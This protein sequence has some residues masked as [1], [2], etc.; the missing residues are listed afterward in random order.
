MLALIGAAAG[1][2]WAWLRDREAPPAPPKPAPAN[3]STDAGEPRSNKAVPTWVLSN[4]DGSAPD[5]HPIKAKETSGI[6]HLPG[7]R[8][9]DRTNPD[10]CYATPEDAQADGYRQAKS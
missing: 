3:E 2:V 5:T 1:A 4:D 10:R 9:Y 6:Y 8:F 7:G